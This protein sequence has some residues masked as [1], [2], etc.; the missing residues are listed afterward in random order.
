[1]VC[2]YGGYVCFL[3]FVRVCVKFLWMLFMCLMFIDIW[4]R[5][6]VILVFVCVILLSWL[7]VVFVG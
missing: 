4:M 3:V 2:E 6:G 5:F 7:W 1:M